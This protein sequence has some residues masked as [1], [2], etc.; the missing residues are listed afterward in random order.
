MDAVLKRAQRNFTIVTVGVA[1]ICAIVAAL[2]TYIYAEQRLQQNISAAKLGQLAQ[3]NS[4]L[5]DYIASQEAYHA[6]FETIAGIIQR[7]DRNQITTSLPFVLGVVAVASGM[8][9]W[10][11]SRRL[12]VPIKESYLSQRRFMQDAAHELRNPL[13]AMSTMLQ[14]AEN[15]P[16]NGAALQ[17]FI[18]SLGRQANH[19][20][21]I[22]TDLLLLEHRDYPGEQ[23]VNIADLLRDV[24]EELHHQAIAQKVAIAPTIPTDLSTK[25]DPQHFVYIAKNLVEN[26]IKFST[27]NGKPV[28]VI[29][30]KSKS[31]WSLRVKDY[32]IGIPKND[33]ANITQRFYRAKNATETDGTGLGLA[34]VAK[35]VTIYGGELHI[36]S[37]P[38]KGTTISV[39][40]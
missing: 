39:T 21:A 7:E 18:Q 30:T 1:I 10:W 9:G 22:T 14:Q 2:G 4:E 13:A 33:I 37:V 23:T 36:D 34:I 15:R 24:L 6:H 17:K 19:L 26:A 25:I 16:P 28:E 5:S 3:D 32:G 35:F 27:K 20:S 40:M 29:L 8:A 38:K 12:L 31:G 11:L